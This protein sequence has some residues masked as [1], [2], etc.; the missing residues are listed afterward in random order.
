MKVTLSRLDIYNKIKT[1]P[2]VFET[3]EDTQGKQY[4]FSTHCSYPNVSLLFSCPSRNRLL[5]THCV[6]NFELCTT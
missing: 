6:F 4:L 3:F 5:L 2:T 1:L